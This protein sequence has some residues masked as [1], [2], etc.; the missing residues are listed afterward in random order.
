MLGGLYPSTGSERR[1]LLLGTEKL[2][3]L[4]SVMNL[5]V[6]LQRKMHVFLHSAVRF[7]CFGLKLAQVARPHLHSWAA[8][9]VCSRT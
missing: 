2:A 9:H 7:K 3:I 5:N 1:V 6:M 8:W 4:A